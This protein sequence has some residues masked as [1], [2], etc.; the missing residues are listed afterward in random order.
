MAIFKV[1]DHRTYAQ[2]LLSK[3]D[4]GHKSDTG[5]TTAHHT[6]LQGDQNALKQLVVNTDSNTSKVK[7]SI[8][9]INKQNYHN[10]GQ[11][12]MGNHDKASLAAFPLPYIRLYGS[13]KTL[14]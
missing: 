13:Y 9:S 12:Y 10:V 8:V 11:N 4:N 5:G 14:G 6:T 7:G 1:R 3:Q 2:V